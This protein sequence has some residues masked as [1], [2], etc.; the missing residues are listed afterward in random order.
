[1][2][3]PAA[4]RWVVGGMAL[5]VGVA[6]LF[7]IATVYVWLLRMIFGSG[8]WEPGEFDVALLAVL[9]V[10]VVLLVRAGRK[11]A[12]RSVAD[13]DTLVIVGVA[14]LG[15]A[16][17]AAYRQRT[18]IDAHLGSLDAALLAPAYMV[19]HAFVPFVVTAAICL[20]VGAVEAMSW[21]R[22]ALVPPA[23]AASVAV[24]LALGPIAFE[25]TRRPASSDDRVV[26]LVVTDSTFTAEPALVPQGTVDL[27]LRWPSFNR[28]TTIVL[29]GPISDSELAALQAGDI[30]WRG[31]YL[32]SDARPDSIGIILGG[33]PNPEG[34]VSRVTL[35]PGT[36]ACFTMVERHAT[37][38][39][40]T[41]TL[42]V[43]GPWATF[44]AGP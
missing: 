13:P 30:E 5:S 15:Y 4:R 1:M 26:H 3:S 8:A 29:A 40:S 35:L 31:E 33:P 42:L 23:V 24:L 19:G 11:T 10:A 20:L 25:D 39:G 36:Y 18:G 28:E 38:G 21:P 34:Y 12:T 44:T 27:E 7:G 9:A 6:M 22:A 32:L 43:P 2:G 17:Y 14:M 16:I 37:V 41:H